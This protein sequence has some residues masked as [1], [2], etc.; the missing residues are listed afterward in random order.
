MA[1][2][3]VLGIDLHPN[4]LPFTQET[5]GYQ[6]SSCESLMGFSVLKCPGPTCRHTSW[7]NR[8]VGMTGNHQPSGVNDLI[9]SAAGKGVKTP[10]I[11]FIISYTL[12][13]STHPCH[14][15]NNIM[16]SSNHVWFLAGGGPIQGWVVWPVVTLCFL[17]DGRHR[18]GWFAVFVYVL[19]YIWWFSLEKYA[20]MVAL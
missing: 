8:G 5:D 7:Y 13:Y 14:W 6:T 9:M 19:F 3:V 20:G 18:L 17:T 2:A 1:L 10:Y 15:L 16:A 4:V 12:S 11:F